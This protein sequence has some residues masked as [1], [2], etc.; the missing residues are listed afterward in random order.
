M[1]GIDEKEDE[2][3]TNWNHL[4]SK[5][6]PC[7]P[8]ATVDD[9]YLT[10]NLVPIVPIGLDITLYLRNPTFLIDLTSQCFD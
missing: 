3:L 4:S 10:H 1:D 6:H 7:G 9:R 5:M 8:I 2:Q